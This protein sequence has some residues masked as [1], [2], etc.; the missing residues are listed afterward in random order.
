MGKK[1]IGVWV[2]E[3]TKAQIEDRLGYGDS[4]SEWVR[5]AIDDRLEH[6]DTDGEDRS[7]PAQTAD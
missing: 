7:T 2:D 1:Q 4:L 5:E 3:E 6:E